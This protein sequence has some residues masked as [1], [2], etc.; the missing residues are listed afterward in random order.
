M[1]IYIGFGRVAACRTARFLVI[2]QVGSLVAQ[3]LDA[4]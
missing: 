2:A 3:R 1:D 4:S